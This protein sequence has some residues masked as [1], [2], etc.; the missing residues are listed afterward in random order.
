MSP[1]DHILAVI[2]VVVLPL[3]GRIVFRRLLAALR[4]G[5]PGA[6]V[7]AYRGT[8]LIQWA[9][10]L[11]LLAGWALAARSWNALGLCLGGPLQSALGAA[12]T[13]GLITLVTLQNR[14]LA[15]LSDE[16]LARL[17]ARSEEIA[18][19]PITPRE[20]AWFTATALTAGVCEE[21]LCR[22]FLLWYLDHWLGSWWSVLAASGLFGM[23][24]LYQ[25]AK[26]VVRT[27]V[28]GGLLAALYRLSGSLLWPILAHAA[29]DLGAGMLSKTIARV[30]AP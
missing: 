21:V 10:T 1:L 7:R 19:L 6:R 11:S 4:V 26:G 27:A 20:R 8:I 16:R 15:R 29:I 2:L 9:L 17:V 23:A 30:R 3:E 24:H 22:G 12:G 13:A 18:L 28:V 5:A 25:G 14:A